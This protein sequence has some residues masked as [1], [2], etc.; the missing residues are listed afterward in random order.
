MTSV[1]SGL[2]FPPLLCVQGIDSC[3]KNTPEETSFHPCAQGANSAAG[4]GV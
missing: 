3:G 2:N 1:I 4:G